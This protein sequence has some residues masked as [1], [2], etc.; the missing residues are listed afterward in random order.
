MRGRQVQFLPIQWRASLK[1]THSSAEAQE[2]IEHDLHNRCVFD[3]SAAS[4]AADADI[5]GPFSYTLDDITLKKSI[6][7]V[8]ELTNSTWP[9]LFVPRAISGIHAD[10]LCLTAA[11]MSS[12]TSLT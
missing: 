3:G 11:K 7:Y 2:D 6:P 8:R 12:S 10:V 9:L 1:L 4:D 5:C